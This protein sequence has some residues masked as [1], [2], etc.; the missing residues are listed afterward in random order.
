MHTTQAH[1]HTHTHTHTHLAEPLMGLLSVLSRHGNKG[2]MRS[3]QI[4]YS[5]G[6][7]RLL[8][9]SILIQLFLYYLQTCLLE[10]KCYFLVDL[11]L[12]RKPSQDHQCYGPQFNSWSWSGGPPPPPPPPLFSNG[13]SGFGS[14][15]F[16]FIISVLI[17]K[18]YLTIMYL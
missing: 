13:N 6:V 4:C 5:N 15:Y 18:S 9:P 8:A 16:K 1:T 7:E 12:L 2:V 11:L 10:S 17:T 3:S 14:Q